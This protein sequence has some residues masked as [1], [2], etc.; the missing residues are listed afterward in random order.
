MKTRENISR[1][2]LYLQIKKTYKALTPCFCT[3]N[4]LVLQKG[5]KKKINDLDMKVSKDFYEEFENKVEVLIEE[6]VKRAKANTRTVVMAR[7][8]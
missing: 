8:L 4:K 1:E 3:M 2:T 6:C 5:V 7:D